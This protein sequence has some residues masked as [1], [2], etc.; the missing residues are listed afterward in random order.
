M[1]DDTTQPQ[2]TNS[3]AP[4]PEPIL[5]TNLSALSDED[6]S[7]LAAR[8]TAEFDA[9]YAAEGGVRAADL[10]RASDLAKA[11]LALEQENDRRGQVRQELAA[12]RDRIVAMRAARQANLAAQAQPDP[13]PTPEPTPEPVSQPDPEPEPVVAADSGRGRTDVRDVIKTPSINASLADASSRAPNPRVPDRRRDDLVVVA[14]KETAGRPIGTQIGDLDSLVETISRFAKST[15]VTRGSPQYMPLATI[16]NTFDRVID[17][18]RTAP[19]EV[20]ALFRELSDPQVLTAA[21]G[22]CAPSE[23]RY[24]FF[25][26]TCDDGLVDLPTFGVT[27]GGITFPI[28]PSMADVFT[29]LLTSDTNPWL[30]TETDDTAA[31]TGDPTK[32]CVRVTCPEFDDVRLEC[33]GICLTAGNLTDSAYPEAVRNHLRL[34]M[35]AHTRAMNTRFL[36]RMQ[37]LSSAAIS[38]GAAG[39]GTA[40][41]LLGAAEMA[42]ID[43][44]TRYGMCQDDILELILP[45]WAK[46]AIRSDLAKRTGV[47]MLDVSDAMI[48]GWFDR[49]RVR[50]QLVNDWQVRGDGNFGDDTAMTAWPTSVDFLIY[51]AGTFVRGTGMSLDLGVVRDSTLNSTND[52]TAAWSEECHLIA[53]FGHE[54]RRYTVAI[55]TD[56]TTGAADLT[57]CGV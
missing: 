33:F 23:T 28:S 27:R 13:E 34:L 48:A 4:A 24:D 35:A 22:W 17:G 54:S 8:V 6:L 57:A 51:A 12:T 40:A 5:P 36:S 3:T 20:E 41:P 55:C 46:G 37:T 39:A 32:P 7:A 9:M 47:D 53:R 30:W 21:G 2:E 56:G 1:P 49:R 52:H 25:N 19:S 10:A 16:R 14:A 18:E 38:V 50:L 15:P 31:A 11:S 42:A 45:V 43:Y 44:R 26:I 29:G